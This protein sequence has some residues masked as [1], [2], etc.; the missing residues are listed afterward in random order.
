MRSE[1]E[2]N[3]SRHFLGKIMSNEE[4]THKISFLTLSG[5]KVEC[6]AP[7]ETLPDSQDQSLSF[8]TGDVQIDVNLGPSN[9]SLHIDPETITEVNVLISSKRHNTS[10]EFSFE[11]LYF[12]GPSFS[13]CANL[14]GPDLPSASGMLQSSKYED[15]ENICNLMLSVNILCCCLM[16]GPRK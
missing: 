7:K 13:C 16:T 10:L 12:R 8:L 2:F 11:H 3:V 4:D 9:T 14:A 6:L 5:K 15:D 1:I